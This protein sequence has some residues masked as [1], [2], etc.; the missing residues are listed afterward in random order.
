MAHGGGERDATE[1]GLY[2]RREWKAAGYKN[3]N[4]RAGLDGG[5]MSLQRCAGVKLKFARRYKQT[6]RL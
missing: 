2:E 3:V 4:G 1:E 5:L 6:F